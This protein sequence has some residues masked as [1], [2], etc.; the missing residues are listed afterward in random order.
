MKPV[1]TEFDKGLRSWT[2]VARIWNAQEN[3]NDSPECIKECGL[4][5]LKK[6]RLLLDERGTTYEDMVNK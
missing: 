3:K 4:K 1:S 6:L 5:A 2:E